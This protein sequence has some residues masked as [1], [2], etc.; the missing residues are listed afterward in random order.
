MAGVP[1]PGL[2]PVPPVAPFFSFPGQNA[3]LDLSG[4]DRDI[5]LY[6]KAILPNVG[7]IKYDLKS[8]GFKSFLE[9][10]RVRAKL[11]GWTE[12]L[13]IPDANGIVVSILDQ[14]GN[15]TM[16]ECRAP[17]TV[18]MAARDRNTQNSVMLYQFLLNSIEE[19]WKTTFVSKIALYSINNEQDG[20]CFLR[21][22][23]SRAQV[24]TLATV[25]VLRNILGNLDKRIV[26]F[27]G[28]V[29][30]FNDPLQIN[31][32]LLGRQHLTAC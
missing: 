21:L 19:K 4:S 11:Y 29:T 3:I 10:V 25:S 23:I 18:Y 6:H 31:W 8:E 24:S 2:L 32:Q 7:S 27:S 13:D 16:D 15:I 26:E 5:K 14:Y 28:N 20:L 22:I 1:P 17:A 30:E 9:S 12:I